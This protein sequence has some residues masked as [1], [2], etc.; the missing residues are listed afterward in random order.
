MKIF[1]NPRD[2][3]LTRLHPELDNKSYHNKTLARFAANQGFSISSNHRDLLYYL[4]NKGTDNTASYHSGRTWFTRLLSNR[5]RN[6]SSV[7]LPKWAR[8]PLGNKSVAPDGILSLKAGAV[9]G[10]KLMGA[11]SGCGLE[12]RSNFLRQ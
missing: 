5:S 2:D 8:R 9:D 12:L 3:W 10:R 6:T 4:R 1:R 7:P 11:I